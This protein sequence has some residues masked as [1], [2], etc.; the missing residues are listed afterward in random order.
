LR[1]I[2]S[3]AITF[4]M[5]GSV[6]RLGEKKLARL[7]HFLKF[8]AVLADLPLWEIVNLESRGSNST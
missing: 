7:P 5:V 2:S 8:A 1:E 6:G 3:V 4:G